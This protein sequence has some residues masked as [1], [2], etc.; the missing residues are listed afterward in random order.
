MVKGKICFVFYVSTVPLFAAPFTDL[1]DGTVRDQRTNLVWQ[2]CSQ[3]VSGTGCATGSVVTS[4]WV[5]ALAY[6]NG[7]TLAARAWRLP[8]ANELA[9]I[10]DRNYFSPAIDVNFF[11]GTALSR[12][13][14]S[15]TFQ[16][17]VSEAWFVNFTA[18]DRYNATKVTAYP[19]RCVA[20][21]P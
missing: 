2:K 3:G 9:S 16:Y 1:G 14:S 11:P 10:V 17:T 21:G 6:C 20:T 13:W 5:N 7:L 12:Y 18:G 8:S 4:T 15:S 19:V